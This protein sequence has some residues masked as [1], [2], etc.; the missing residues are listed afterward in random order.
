MCRYDDHRQGG[1]AAVNRDWVKGF[2]VGIGAAVVAPVVFPLLARSAR[3]AMHAAIRAGVNA[4]EKGRVRV[5]EL[6]EYAEDMVAEARATRGEP[7][8]QPVDLAGG[9]ESGPGNG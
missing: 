4:Y 8:P 3:P 7:P 2:A 1:E 6:G 9:L 5:A